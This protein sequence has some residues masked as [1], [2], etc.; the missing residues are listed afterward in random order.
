[1]QKD[2]QAGFSALFDFE[3]DRYLTISIVKLVY[4]LAFAFACLFA[5][6][7]TIMIFTSVGAAL[8]MTG[9]AEAGLIQ[10]ML[11]TLVAMGFF[12]FLALT[13]LWLEAL[14]VHFKGNEKA[15]SQDPLSS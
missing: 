11:L 2:V 12:I 1:M 5:L 7:W 14:V 9:S 15:L 3:F 13:R 8:R 4:K 6:S 10:L